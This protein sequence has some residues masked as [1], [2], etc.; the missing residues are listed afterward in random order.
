MDIVTERLLHAEWKHKGKEE[1]SEEKAMVMTPRRPKRKVLCYNCKKHGHFQWECPE[2]SGDRREWKRGDHKAHKAAKA[3]DDTSD[4]DALVVG[5]GAL[6]VGVMTS[7]W[8]VDSGATCHMCRCRSSF[9]EYQHLKKPEKVI[10][11]TERVLT[12]LGAV[13]LR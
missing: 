11:G 5:H 6:S 1:D 13:Q 3:G 2:S 4:S 10:L 12:L 7:G 9:V 8:I